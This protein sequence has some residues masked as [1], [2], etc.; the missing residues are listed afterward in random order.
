MLYKNLFG[1]EIMNLNNTKYFILYFSNV[2]LSSF[3]TILFAEFV[4]PIKSIGRTFITVEEKPEQKGHIMEKS[5]SELLKLLK[6]FTSGM[7]NDTLIDNQIKSSNSSHG[8]QGSLIWE[9]KA[10]DFSNGTFPQSYDET[11]R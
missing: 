6:A 9:A 11:L 10:A 1:L 4:T 8:L 2:K 5:G 7:T 3:F